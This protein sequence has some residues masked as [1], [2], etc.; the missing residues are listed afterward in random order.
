VT[1]E[2]LVY[3]VAQHGGNNLSACSEN[4]AIKPQFIGTYDSLGTA[5]VLIAVVLKIVEHLGTRH[6]A[7][8][9]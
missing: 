8:A 9:R 2:R 6:Y 1:D 3:C 7:G 4:Q 5:T